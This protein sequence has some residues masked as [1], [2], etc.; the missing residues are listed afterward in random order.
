MY[1]ILK[2]QDAD[3]DQKLQKI[4]SEVSLFDKDIALTVTSIIDDVVKNKD[5]AV[6]NYTKKF[7]NVELDQ[8]SIRVSE[9]EF[10]LGLAKCSDNIIEALHVSYARVREYHVRQLP[11]NEKFVDEAGVTL[12]WKWQPISS[13]GLY[14]PG[15][16]AFYPSSV[17][18]NALPA[19]VAGV[20]RI[21]IAVP[22]PN[23]EINPTLLA[24][25]KICGIDEI[26]KIGG[27]QAIAAL[28]YGTES[29]KPVDKIVGPGNAYVAEAK[30]QVFGKVGIDMIAGPS[31]I[32]V[33]ADNDVD[34]RWIAADLLSQAEHDEKARSILITDDEKFARNVC[35]ETE[36]LIEMIGKTDIAAKSIKDNG[37]IIIVDSL[38]REATK[39]ANIIAPEHLEI[40]TK[41]PENISKRI[42]NAGAIFLGNYTPEAVGDYI[43]GPS[44][45]IPTSGS[46]RFFSGLGVLDFMKRT[47]MVK[48]SKDALELLAEPIISLANEE[49]LDAH[50]LSVSLRI[51]QEEIK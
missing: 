38:E 16:K 25:A 49:R 21:A 2:Y 45:V 26:Y 13:V 48:S 31:E 9:E 11:I 28:A 51:Q 20:N 30:R 27:A 8:S 34:P 14:V 24:A 7:D 15:G 36:I 22:T 10:Q 50:A 37:H 3:F 5:Q 41:N 43:A 23:G 12:G 29:V 40:C 19:I 35:R 4:T 17:I 18:M 42:N 33:I 32:L 39:I 47:S 46:A 44:H 6:F 1:N